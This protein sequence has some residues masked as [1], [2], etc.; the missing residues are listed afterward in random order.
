MN[1]QQYVLM[2]IGIWIAIAFLTF[3]AIVFD[4]KII[5]IVD[6]LVV[7]IAACISWCVTL[8]LKINILPLIRELGVAIQIAAGVYGIV[9][10]FMIANSLLGW[11]GFIPNIVLFPLTVW[12]ATPL[13]WILHGDYVP[14]LILYGGL[15]IGDLIRHSVGRPDIV[16][17]IVEE[18]RIRRM[19][20]D[21]LR[22]SEDN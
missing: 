20:L 17:Q 8:N 15:L 7:V 9:I 10:S 6:F 21:N 11:W 1:K 22:K 16:E 14:T 19:E 12:F 18:D 3:I 2:W 5:W 13:K 4:N